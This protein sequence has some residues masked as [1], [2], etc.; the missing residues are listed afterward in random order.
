MKNL[1]ENTPQ[2]PQ[3][4]RKVKDAY[5]FAYF[6]MQSR[7]A[8]SFKLIADLLGVGTS[9][10]MNW[11]KGNTF[12]MEERL[13]DIAEVYGVDFSELKDKFTLAKEARDKET[14]KQKEV[15]HPTQK[16]IKPNPDSEVY[17]GGGNG[18]GK[19]FKQW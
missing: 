9:V 5:V 10:V 11:E 17:L 12:P 1:F 4:E 18:R 13:A 14:E 7:G 16:I 3:P 19:R 6:L 8:K 15:R 2:T